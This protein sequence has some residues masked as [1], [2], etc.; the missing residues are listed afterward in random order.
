MQQEK[1]HQPWLSQSPSF[2]LLYTDFADPTEFFF[3][4]HGE[5]VLS[6]RSV[7]RNWFLSSDNEKTIDH[8][9]IS[10]NASHRPLNFGWSDSTTFRFATKPEIVLATSSFFQPKSFAASPSCAA[11]TDRK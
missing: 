7:Y 8:L 6:V 11:P 4:F 5:P 2:R 9:Q 1:D 3:V 10:G